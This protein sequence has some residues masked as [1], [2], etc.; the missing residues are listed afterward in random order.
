MT[1]NVRLSDEVLENV[2]CEVES[3]I[4][5][6]PI[7]KLSDDPNDFS[8]LTPNRLLLLRHSPVLP[9]GKFSGHDMYR[10]RWRH[11]QYIADQFWR[12][13]IRLYLPE[14]QRR[15]KW[16]D[17]KRNLSVGDLV[18]IVDE[19]TPRN[20]WPLALVKEVCVGRDGLVR[21]VK[22]RSRSSELVR[23]ITKI[24]LLEAVNND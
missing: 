3:I 23:P 16:T 13:W 9:P 19:N 6:R 15:V 14:L 18:L 10:R 5:G 4:N 17:K 2:L 21:S 11:A 22:L 1:V 20:L 8:R 24:V 7:T 12:K